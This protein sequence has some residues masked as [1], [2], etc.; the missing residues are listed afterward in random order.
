[1]PSAAASPE[2]LD[3]RYDLLGDRLDYLRLL[4]LE[5]GLVAA[6]HDP[7]GA[8]AHV[9]VG[10][11][12]QAANLVPAQAL[13]LEGVHRHRDSRERAVAAVDVDRPAD[14]LEVL[15]LGI[16]AGR[17]S[18]SIAWSIVLR[19]PSRNSISGSQPSRSLARAMSGW[20]TFGSSTGSASNT[21]S[22]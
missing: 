6:A 16:H 9:R 14:R 10:A 1:M 2:L 13:D 20:R 3:Q 7:E 11:D 17:A 12:R 4:F 5:A 19:R 22:E 8:G 15:A 18:C 21:I